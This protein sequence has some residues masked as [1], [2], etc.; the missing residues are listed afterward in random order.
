MVIFSFK[1]NG[2]VALS[3]RV[4]W[5]VQVL[6]EVSH[7]ISQCLSPPTRCYTLQEDRVLLHSLPGA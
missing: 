7:V 6:G 1:M 3:S 5:H 2:G 4:L